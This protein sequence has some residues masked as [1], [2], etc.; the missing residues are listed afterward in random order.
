M[1]LLARREDRLRSIADEIQ[2]KHGVD[3]YLAALDVC[4]PDEI[5]RLPG[6]LPVGFENI[7][8]LINNAGLALELTAT[9]DMDPASID[10]MIDTNV[11]GLL[12]MTHA[13]LPGM[14]ARGHGHVINIGSTAGHTVYPGGT[15]YCATKHAVR[16]ITEGLQMDVHGT[17]IR[18]SSVDP[19]LVETEF[20]MVRFSGDRDRAD[21]VYAG[22]TPLT[23]EDI[24]DVVHYVASRPAHVNISD[25]VLMPLD[26]SS[27]TLVHRRQ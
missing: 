25:V 7:D 26:Q 9:Q 6:S 27:P 10:R 14:I 11:R 24:A 23:A 18:V 19:G 4:R 12:H 3:A 21:A 2:S 1:I 8:I 15:V 20:S 22:M 5:R 13:L 16:A 17:G